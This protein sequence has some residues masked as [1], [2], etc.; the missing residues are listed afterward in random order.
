MYETGLK[1]EEKKVFWTLILFVFVLLKMF[2]L[3]FLSTEIIFNLFGLHL[4]QISVS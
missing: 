3:R 2:D 4:I 1:R